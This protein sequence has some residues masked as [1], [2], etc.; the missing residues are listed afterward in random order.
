MAEGYLAQA[1]EILIE[2][3]GAA[4]RGVWNLVVRRCQETVELALKA[5]LRLAG[6]EV[7]RI[8]DVG[9]LLKDHEEKFPEAFRRDIDRLASI[10][11][12]LRREREAS[13]YGDEE[14]GA[15]PQ[16]LYTEEDSRQAL[17]DADFVLQRCHHLSA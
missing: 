15:A 12:R 11:R 9:M 1:V 5:A 10:S 6:I 8:H 2:A 7:P 14:T 13:F 3:R 16:R 17:A 4:G